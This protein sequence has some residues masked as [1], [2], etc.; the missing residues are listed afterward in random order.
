MDVLVEWLSPN[1]DTQMAV[2]LILDFMTHSLSFFSLKKKISVSG[3]YRHSW[4]SWEVLSQKGPQNNSPDTY[5]SSSSI[6]KM[7]NSP[8]AP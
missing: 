3:L 8:S 2:T 1:Y 6:F 7:E 4:L 5:L